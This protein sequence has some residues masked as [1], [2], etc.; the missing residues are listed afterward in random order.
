MAAVKLEHV[1]ENVI[2]FLPSKEYSRCCISQ[3]NS[4]HKLCHSG[5]EQFYALFLHNY[6]R[7][8][9][10]RCSRAKSCV[11]RKIGYR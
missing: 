7:P 5:M 6:E 1:I 2:Q 11:N 8:I 9:A 10:Q 4:C 3:T